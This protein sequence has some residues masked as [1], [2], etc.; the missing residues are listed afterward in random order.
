MSMLIAMDVQSRQPAPPAPL[1]R[2]PIKLQG[3]DPQ[4]MREARIEYH[5]AVARRQRQ[6]VFDTRRAMCKCVDTMIADAL[7]NAD[8]H[9]KRWNCSDR[10]TRL[11][12]YETAL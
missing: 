8:S 12:E 1:G 4:D 11:S 6:N 3:T 7:A 10:S 2:Q 5:F 9:F